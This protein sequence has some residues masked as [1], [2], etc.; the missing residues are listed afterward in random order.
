M[1]LY[2]R[3][4]EI[5]AGNFG[6]ITSAEAKGVGAS[7]KELSRLTSSGKLKRIGR[8][9]YRVMHHVPEPLDQ[10]AEAVALTG[11]GAYVFGESVIAMLDLAPTN[12]T[13]MTIATFKR[14]RRT[15]PPWLRVV[16]GNDADDITV[17][18]GIP[19]QTVYGAISSCKTIMMTDRLLDA[20]KAA[21]EQGYLTRREEHEL[22]DLLGGSDEEAEQQNASRQCDT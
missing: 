2:D 14:V 13:R 4:Y 19:S 17:Y 9:V 21:K 5:A 3:I 16:R 20:V 6:L 12:P 11:P 7:D 18:D 22:I 8:G 10:Y 15:L 1:I